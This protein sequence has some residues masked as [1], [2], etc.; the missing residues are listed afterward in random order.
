[1][2]YRTALLLIGL[3]AT[4]SAFAAEPHQAIYEKALDDVE[5]DFD[6]RWAYTETRVDSEHVWVGRYDPRRASSERWQIVS[7]DGR[8]PTEKESEEFLEGKRRDHSGNNDQRVDALVDTDSVRLVDETS[9]FWLFGFTPDEEQEVLDSI[10]ATMRIDKTTGQLDY[11]DMRNHEPIKPGY[12][13]KISKLITRLTFAPA[14]DGGPVV[15]VSTQVEVQGR[16]YL[17]IS[18]DEEELIRNSDFEFV[19]DP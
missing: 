12:G 13:V 17:L 7:I 14:I 16:A 1:M 10:E 2:T 8:D 11:I 6:E 4:T 18:F 3:Y 19:G 9:E 15:P 5:F